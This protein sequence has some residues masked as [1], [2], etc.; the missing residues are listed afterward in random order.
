ML[1]DTVKAIYVK[2]YKSWAVFRLTGAISEH[3]KLKGSRFV[4]G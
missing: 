2:L 1:P 4:Y 3:I